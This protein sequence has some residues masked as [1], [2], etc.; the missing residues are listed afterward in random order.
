M[1]EISVREARRLIGKLD[2]ILETEGD[3]KIT[4]RG[5]PIAKVS[6]LKNTRRMPSRKNLWESMRAMDKES[7]DLIRLDR[8]DR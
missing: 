4:R 7:A 6:A 8:D 1:K 5:K 3:V 2:S